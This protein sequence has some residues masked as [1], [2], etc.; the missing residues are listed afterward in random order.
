MT[1]EQQFGGRALQ[2]PL[3]SLEEHFWLMEKLVPRGHLLAVR[4]LGS[5]P[6]KSW[7]EAFQE[8]QRCHPMLRVS[9]GKQ[10]GE[11]PYFYEV[12]DR[13]IPLTFYEW[14]D[15]SSLESF[16]ESEI[17]KS[18]MGG[19]GALTRVSVFLGERQSAVVIASH[20]AVF[21]GIDHQM[22]L[23]E[24]LALLDGRPIEVRP[25]RLSSSTS[26]LYGRETLPYSGRSPLNEGD[27][28]PETTYS[29]PPIR[30]VRHKVD[31]E[32]VASALTACRAR[33]LGFRSALLTALARA[34][35]RLNE[36]WRRDGIRALTPLDARSNRGL[37]GRV[38]M[39][40]VLHRKV[41]VPETPFW[42]DVEDMH[43]SLGPSEIPEIAETLFSLAEQLVTEEHSSM[44]HLARIAGTE[45]V[46]DLMLTNY[47]VLD[48]SGS[49]RFQID[50]IFTAGVAGH[51]ETQKVAALTRNGD[52]TL[53]LVGQA[54]LQRFLET[55]MEEL[56]RALP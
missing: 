1:G 49:K 55:A 6:E 50:D 2:R 35:F 34:G 19:T 44:S 23:Q 56:E 21:D 25:N 22:I 43:R 15:S 41:F 33:Q 36:E 27:P 31:K 40:M 13:S 16:V 7:R 48:W 5:A 9:I 51:F 47:G 29:T 3:D 24:V 54:P 53:T 18:F 26:S 12:P 38:G 39:C 37:D 20:H 17:L 4:L 28:V 11:R 52:L 32:L 14:T 30:I 45:F 46:H 10:A 8:V 42:E